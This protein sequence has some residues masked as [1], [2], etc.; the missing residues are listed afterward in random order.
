MAGGTAVLGGL[1]AG[2]ALAVLGFVIGAKAGANREAA[3]SNLAKA[4]EYEEEMKTAETL[5]RGIHMRAD[6]FYRL[7]IRLESMFDPLVY[8]LE[9]TIAAVGTDY[10][11]YSREQKQ[12]VAKALSLAGALLILR[13]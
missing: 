4:A 9:K 13:F 3:Y 7:L 1:V 2:P 11:M 10:R 5:C 8:E 12:T 6:M